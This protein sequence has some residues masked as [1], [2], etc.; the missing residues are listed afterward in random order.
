MVAIRKDSPT[1]TVL[2]EVDISIQGS[3]G[4][5]IKMSP[6]A[7]IG[8]LGAYSDFGFWSQIQPDIGVVTSLTFQFYANSYSSSAIFLFF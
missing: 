7:C 1:P 2:V 5:V 3:A 4:G 8:L 6:S